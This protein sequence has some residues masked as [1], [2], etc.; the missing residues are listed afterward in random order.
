MDTSLHT[1]EMSVDEAVAFMHERALLP[2]P[3]ARSEVARYCAWPTQA[4]AYLT[5]AMAIERARDDWVAGGGALGI[6]TTLWPSPAACRCRWLSGPSGSPSRQPD[7]RY[8]RC[9]FRLGP[10]PPTLSRE[11][12]AMTEAEE[13]CH[14]LDQVQEVVPSSNGCEDC[15][16]SVVGGCTSG[17][18]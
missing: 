9:R 7:R 4:S 8:H 6:S 1:G 17:C 11:E 18:A 2:L 15:L 13:F 3:T 14:H 16:P 5:G 10:T 12:T